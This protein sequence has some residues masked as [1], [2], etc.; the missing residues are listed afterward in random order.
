MRPATTPAAARRAVRL[1]LP[2]RYGERWPGVG[3]GDGSVGGDVRGECGGE[4]SAGA[5]DEALVQIG[6]VR[7]DRGCTPQRRGWLRRARRPAWRRAV[8][9]RRRRH[10]DQQAALFRRAGSERSRRPPA[11][12]VGRPIQLRSRERCRSAREPELAVPPARLRVRTR[13]GPGGGSWWS[14]ARSMM[15]ASEIVDRIPETLLSDTA[16]GPAG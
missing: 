9:C 11:A 3:D 1:P 8:L 14:N 4:A 5:A 2:S 10:H 7:P 6:A 12:R 15:M 13:V 16:K